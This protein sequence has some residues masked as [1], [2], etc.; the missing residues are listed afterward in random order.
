[1][2]PGEPVVCHD[3]F[4]GAIVMNIYDHQIK[5]HSDELT[6]DAVKLL[7]IE[8]N[9][10]ERK[11]FKKQI[12]RLPPQVEESGD[13]PAKS[14]V[15]QP[16]SLF[17]R[18]VEKRKVEKS[19]KISPQMEESY[20]PARSFTFSPGV[21][22]KKKEETS[23]NISPQI[24][25]S[26]SAAK[27]LTVEQK[28]EEKS[29]DRK[30]NKIL[31]DSKRSISDADSVIDRNSNKKKRFSL[32]E[33]ADRPNTS[34]E[35]VYSDADSVV[36][37]STIKTNKKKR[38][39][40]NESTERLNNNNETVHS[41]AEQKKRRKRKEKKKKKKVSINESAERP[42]NNNETVYSDRNSNKT[43]KKK[44]IKKKSSIS[45]DITLQ[46]MIVESSEVKP[47]VSS[48]CEDASGFASELSTIIINDDNSSREI[49][50]IK[51]EREAYPETS[52]SSNLL[53]DSRVS[54][55]SAAGN[56]VELFEPVVFN[57][58]SSNHDS[59]NSSVP[60]SSPKLLL[61]V[62]KEKCDSKPAIV[63]KAH[64]PHELLYKIVVGCP[65]LIYRC[66][67]PSSNASL[68]DALKVQ[69]MLMSML[70]LKTG[71]LATVI[72]ACVC[73]IMTESKCD[74]NVL[75]LTENERSYYVNFVMTM[76]PLIHSNPYGSLFNNHLGKLNR[77]HARKFISDFWDEAKLGV[78]SEMF[79]K[80]INSMQSPNS[81]LNCVEEMS[82]NGIQI[83]S[84]DIAC[85]FVTIE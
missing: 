63:S 83:R 46:D 52:N 60:C 45:L 11:I 2:K 85:E 16:T 65:G 43:K 20:S 27:S 6:E 66:S 35:T 53:S 59:E 44:S 41:D 34:N 1:M 75:M 36:D 72:D 84:E 40:L 76:R 23:N 19:N 54:S 61:P 8:S 14:S 56:S 81:S 10:L 18:S 22:Q 58:F 30:L 73:Q 31:R 49:I 78:S 39:S 50:S 13:S 5:H 38:V 42:N 62:K 17:S 26:Y 3:L 51:E 64:T 29:N 55:S 12:S 9:R 28:K 82:S 68:L 67:Q 57:F 74:N 71:S 77:S 80:T 32:S 79:W 25:E 21:S 15:S 37:R 24:E 47:D 7:T 4:C 69:G 33:S 70:C 48:L